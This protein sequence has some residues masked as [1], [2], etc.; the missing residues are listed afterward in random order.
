MVL[1]IYSYF[2][3]IHPP[4]FVLGVECRDGVGNVSAFAEF[5]RWNSGV[6]REFLYWS[7]D[8]DGALYDGYDLTLGGLELK[9]LH[10]NLTE[11]SVR[12]AGSGYSVV[13][14]CAGHYLSVE[15][16]YGPSC[17]DRCFD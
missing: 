2:F 11:M 17:D 7:I 4:I 3:V 8:V 14:R 9:T 12:Y 13:N 1:G 5:E 6:R 16:I 10:V 15:V